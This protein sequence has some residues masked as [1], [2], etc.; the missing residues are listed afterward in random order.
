MAAGRADWEEITP[1]ELISAIKHITD[2]FDRGLWGWS[3]V[4]ENLC[5]AALHPGDCRSAD[6]TPYQQALVNLRRV[7]NPIVLQQLDDQLRTG[8]PPSIFH[9]YFELYRYAWEINIDEQFNAIFQIAVANSSSLRTQPVEWAKSHLELLI[10]GNA[11]RPRRWVKETCDKKDYTEDFKEMVFWNTWRAPKLIHMQPSGNTLYDPRIAWT[12][13][14]T[15]TNR[16]LDGLCR[17]FIQF[18]GFQLDKIVG[19]AHVRVAQ[20]ERNPHV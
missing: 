2:E 9:A 20:T 7:L 5:Y 15:A 13:E 3:Q 17:R 16:L 14:E 8:T 1:N 11:Y 12:R 19:D 18:V 6:L 10:K 4:T